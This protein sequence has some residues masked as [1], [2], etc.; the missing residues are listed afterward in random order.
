MKSPVF[1]FGMKEFITQI[2]VSLGCPSYAW[3]ITVLSDFIVR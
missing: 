1:K 3:I 2:T